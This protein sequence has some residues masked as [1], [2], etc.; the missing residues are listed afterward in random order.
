MHFE[1]SIMIFFMFT[2]RT[3]KQIAYIRPLS[4]TNKIKIRQNSLFI[5]HLEITLSSILPKNNYISRRNVFF[6]KIYLIKF[7]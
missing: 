5:T 3:R 4:L 7:I 1:S 6:I 2:I